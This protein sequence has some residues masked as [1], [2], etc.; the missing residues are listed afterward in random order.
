MALNASCQN[1]RRN[2]TLHQKYRWYHF[3][4][5]QWSRCA[6]SYEVDDH[7]NKEIHPVATLNGK[8]FLL[9]FLAGWDLQTLFCYLPQNLHII[10]F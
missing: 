9:A 7:F 8:I 4:I 2:A 3:T 1:R 6:V 5:Q 10:S